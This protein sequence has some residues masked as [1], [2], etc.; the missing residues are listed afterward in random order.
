[1]RYLLLPLFI[2]ICHSSF[3]QNGYLPLDKDKNV[4]Y[5]DLG[6]P[7]KSRD[8]VYS[9]VQK[10]IVKTFGNYEN[11]VKNE[12]PSTGRLFITSYR[13]VNHSTFE[14]I[15]FDLIV[16]CTDS[17]YKA[18]IEKL[19]GIASL[20]PPVHLSFRDNDLINAQEVIAKAEINR[21]KRA[22]EETR[23][24]LAKENLEGINSA[25][26]GLLANL[27]VFMSSDESK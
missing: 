6:K 1:L 17:L 20:L 22:L 19:D 8:E 12:E 2:L 25:M 14:H 5:S 4:V 11:A 23:L 10:W 16:E 9:D 15:R 3:S 7:Q 27:K 24:Q 13:P 26:Y 21:K 18:R